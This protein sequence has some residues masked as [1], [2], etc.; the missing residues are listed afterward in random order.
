MNDNCYSYV[1]E[2]EHEDCD[3]VAGGCSGGDGYAEWYCYATD[4][5]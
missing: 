4:M 3:L 2:S 1:P 5:T